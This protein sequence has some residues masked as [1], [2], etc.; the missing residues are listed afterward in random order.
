MRQRQH[1]FHVVRKW[2]RSPVTTRASHALGYSAFLPAALTLAHL[3][4]AISASLAF[5]AGL[6][7]RSAFLMALGE[8]TGPLTFAHLAFAA[9]LIAALPA[10]LKR[11]ALFIGAIPLALAHLAL[12]AAEIFARATADIVRFPPVVAAGVE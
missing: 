10:A 1:L 2:R 6:I 11:L 3:A 8:E 5:T 12:A 7:R 4:L 9:A